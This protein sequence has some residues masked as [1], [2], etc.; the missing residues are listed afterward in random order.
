MSILKSELHARKL[1]KIS[2]DDK[3]VII[4]VEIKNIRKNMEIIS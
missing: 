4:G 2:K 1:K 3:C